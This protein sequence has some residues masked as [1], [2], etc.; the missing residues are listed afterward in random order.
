MSESGAFETVVFVGPKGDELRFHFHDGDSVGIPEP[1][2]LGKSLARVQM[3]DA[4]GWATTSAPAFYDLYPG[5]G[6]V[7]RFLATGNTNERGAL[8]SF[9]DPRGRVLTPDDFGVDIVRDALGNIRQVKTLTR[10]ADVRTL[11]PTHYAVTVY[12]LAEEP[13]QVADTG[14]YALPEH[15]P[16]RVLD[17]AQGESVKELL[18]GFQKGT[19][20]MRQY[21]YVAV[22]GDWTLYQPSGLVEAQELYFTEDESGAQRLHTIRD[23]TGKLWSRDEY[24]YVSA[25]WG[26]LITNRI[27][28]IPG[29]ATRTTSWSY[30]TDGPHK[31]LL[32][33]TVE[34]TGN[35]ILYEYD[36]KNRVVRESMPLVEEETL[37]SYEPV[38]PS[39]PPLLC[40]TRPR[41]I[42][43]KMQGIEI[44]RT[45]YVYGTNGVDVVERVGEQG[46][47]YGGTNVLRTVTT[48]YPV[49]GAIT[50]GLVQSVRHEDGTIDNYAYDLTDGVWTETVTHVHEQAPAIVPMRTT[51]SVR[52]HNAL[53]KLIDSRTDLCTIGVEDLVPQA[54]WT[55]IERLQY[56]YDVDGNEIRRE[57]LA[58]RLWTAEWAGNCCGKVSETDWQGI[59]TA[60]TY[61]S[62]ENLSIM[63]LFLPSPVET[64]FS[65][66]A[67][68]RQHASWKTNTDERLGT[69]PI[70]V[71]YDSLNRETDYTD[72]F[73][74]SWTFF[75]SSNGLQRTSISPRG[76]WTIETQDFAGRFIGLQD[77]MKNEQ[78]TSF[79]SVS[80]GSTVVLRQTGCDS[81][82]GPWSREIYNMLGQL[83]N[84]TSSGAAGN[85]ISKD[86]SYDAYGNIVE[87]A[88]S[89]T[90]IFGH[91]AVDNRTIFENRNWLQREVLIAV[92]VNL[93]G[94]VDNDGTDILE[95]RSSQFEFRA[96][97]LCKSDYSERMHPLNLGTS[98]GRVSVVRKL[99]NVT[100][101]EWVAAVSYTDYHMNQYVTWTC[102]NRTNSVVEEKSANSLGTDV[103]IRKS[104]HGL[105]TEILSDGKTKEKYT[106]DGIGRI[107]KI[108]D[109]CGNSMTFSYDRFN[110][111]TKVMDEGG[112][113]ALL[114]YSE[115]GDLAEIVDPLGNRTRIRYDEAGRI[116]E[117]TGD[118]I[119]FRTTY[120]KFGF[121]DTIATHRESIDETNVVMP[122]E[123][124]WLFD[125]TTGLVTNKLF[126]NGDSIL[127]EYRFDGKP[128][129]R[130]SARGIETV[131][132][133]GEAGL[134]SGIHYS[135]STPD[136]SFKRNCL[137]EIIEAVS[138]NVSTSRFD[139]VSNP[140]WPPDL[141]Y[142]VQN[143]TAIIR[144]RD[145][146][147]RICRT[148][149]P[150]G[151]V[152]LEY[153]PSGDVAGL[154]AS[155]LQFTNRW[156]FFKVPGT[157]MIQGV[158][159]PIGVS[160]T[161]DYES[162]CNRIVAI[163]NDVVGGPR[164][165]FV[166]QND[167]SG[168]RISR[169]DYSGT[170]LVSSNS[171]QN[172]SRSEIVAAD[173]NG[174]H[175]GFQYDCAGNRVKS[176]WT[177][178]LPTNS[179]NCF[180][181]GFWSISKAN[182]PISRSESTNRVSETFEYDADGNLLE[183][184]LWELKWDAENR[185]VEAREKP[186][187][188]GMR[189][190]VSYEY[191][192]HGRL[193][194]RQ[195]TDSQGR[196]S[197]SLFLYDGWNIVRETR[198]DNN[199]VETTLDFVWGIDF[200]GTVGGA[201]GIGGLL[202]VIINDGVFF[203]AYD[204]NGNI[205]SYHST[206]GETVASYKYG[207][208][209]ELLS[210]TGSLSSIFPHRFST[211][212][213]DDA[214]GFYNF[215]YRIYDPRLG[216]WLSRDPIGE[217][218]G[219][220]LYGMVNNNPVN[221]WDSLGL[222]EGGGISISTCEE[223]AKQFLERNKLPL[224]LHNIYIDTG[225]FFKV[226]EWDRSKI[227]YAVTD[228]LKRC[229][230][231]WKCECCE[232]IGR[233]AST[234]TPVKTHGEDFFLAPGGGYAKE[235]F[236]FTGNNV[237]LC[238]NRLDSQADLDLSFF[239][240]FQ[241]VYDAC[242]DSD[243]LPSRP[244]CDT[245]DYSCRCARQLCS[246]FRIR[247]ILNPGMS[248]DEIFNSIIVPYG[249]F[250][251]GSSIRSCKMAAI[252]A[253]APDVILEL[254]NKTCNF[255]E[256]L[257]P[258]DR[259]FF[260]PEE[261]QKGQSR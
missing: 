95:K 145:D 233:M 136:V 162:P 85:W 32:R 103:S 245:E 66:D 215:G 125:S 261:R 151:T 170:E 154:T 40:D 211:K 124:R 219:I 247:S 214:T 217:A 241:H 7:W 14:L 4:E 114:H 194:Q 182:Q 122:D 16:T 112:R 220:N 25:Y 221:S 190:V 120:G 69:Q 63:T 133:Y 168:R 139:Y 179:E 119:H 67:L 71:N 242:T 88:E 126:P 11:S 38:D 234:E 155:F 20:D 54:D 130:K 70:Y 21:R 174:I 92:D 230:V 117:R 153:S 203:P 53:G 222:E 46:A 61:D 105:L 184:G 75:W 64:H 42:V 256:G 86:Y 206:T 193:I 107:V 82:S 231:R 196:K 141:D 27:E 207:P 156:D 52:V 227:H 254:A 37:Y 83:I 28:G 68:N 128:A 224:A 43:R 58:G 192:W 185:L 132:Q 77:S 258:K 167:D 56:A 48:Y 243:V 87:Y 35:R 148:E 187:G 166:Y 41:C 161:R 180:A 253:V 146:S 209:G 249:Y 62:N 121:V 260:S 197:G 49:T 250:S 259:F 29:D 252:D 225:E 189:R 165:I 158:H 45:Y 195:E 90:D 150:G 191:D 74:T 59:T 176:E 181:P 188:N 26:Y 15:A 147:M 108:V 39:D 169:M 2:N 213:R 72:A 246:E 98:E 3:V 218:G 175:F 12:P 73:G 100:T 144:H 65:Y 111:M 248:I 109:A 183:N 30:Y 178:N 17:V 1:N 198:M 97:Y 255:T 186:N 251:K 10:L 236:T 237:T 177:G 240:E 76:T 134:L 19:G 113:K 131:Y 210:S 228:K 91:V 212:P 8:V 78:Q 118:N 31:D 5:D 149:Y 163:S 138:A 96:G 50:D 34:P 47:A 143:G 6:S 110:N 33:E 104:S 244:E 171:F 13:E 79:F 51:R 199:G 9:T 232:E 94:I 135:D 172:S 106:Y 89:H 116:V 22:N 101:Q 129:K 137:G 115:F 201:G 152:T 229:R 36:D 257:L 200:S 216:R 238:F 208:F 123:T 102:V 159:S 202:A 60:Y 140:K 204:A 57:D 24:N 84:Q 160:W 81:S 127:Y 239:H 80:N 23:E 99:I 93:N 164:L 44:Q 173:M 55:P 223:Y 226:S 157:H 142:E 18:V 205:V 235:A